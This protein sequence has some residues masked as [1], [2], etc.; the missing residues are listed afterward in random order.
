MVKEENEVK[1]L[2]LKLIESVID[3]LMHNHGLIIECPSYI[4]NFYAKLASNTKP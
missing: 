3:F 2:I 4:S 1:R